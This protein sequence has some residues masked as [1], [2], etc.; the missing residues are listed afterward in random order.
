M[1]RTKLRRLGI[2]TV[3]L[4]VTAAVVSLSAAGGSGPTSAGATLTATGSGSVTFV[5]D[6]ATLDF[7]ASTQ[8]TKA[9]AAISANA[10]AMNAIIAALKQAGASHVSTNTVS[11]SAQYN[12]EQTAI[13]G[14]Q[15][16]NSVH[17]SVAVDQVGKIIDAA[18][19]AGATNINGPSFASSID[20]ESLYRTALRS[21]I[22]QAR[23]RAGVIADAAGVTLGHI[24]SIDPGSNYG[25]TAVPASASSPP[26]TPV[27]PPTQQV[28]ASVTLVFAAS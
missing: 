19:A 14:F 4:A 17:A 2:A 16:S 6:T 12:R 15:T 10:G 11:L 22:V 21:A 9:D 18:V 23:A 25:A 8:R 28:T 7:G 3:I 24:V 20:L 26:S 27:L 13:T 1:A 5:P